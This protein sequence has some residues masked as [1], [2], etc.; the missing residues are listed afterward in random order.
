LLFSYGEVLHYSAGPL[1]IAEQYLNFEWTVHYS[2]VWDNYAASGNPLDGYTNV[3]P[4]DW[5]NK[6][7][8]TIAGM[9]YHYGGKDSFEQWDSDYEN[10]NRGPGAHSVHLNG[11]RN[12]LSWAAGIDCSGF[13]GRCW[14]VAEIGNCNCT[15]LTQ[16]S[17]Q[18]PSIQVQ[19]GDAFIR[20]AYDNHARLCYARI[21]DALQYQWVDVIE[22]ASGDYD[23]V[24]KLHIYNRRANGR[25]FHVLLILRLHQHRRG[26]V[27][28][29][30]TFND[31]PYMINGHCCGHTST[32]TIEAGVNV[33]FTGHYS[34][35]VNAGCSRRAPRT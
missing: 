13:V 10:G 7:G 6:I 4:C 12:S 5:V 14:E 35:T 16:Q 27:S 9:P 1:E 23:K 34:F 24:V 15:Y 3:Y 2:N 20:T 17:T 29:T 19:P 30:W 26:S 18:I 33:I 31:G 11:A 32:L 22:A 28:G 25:K 8:T 21:E